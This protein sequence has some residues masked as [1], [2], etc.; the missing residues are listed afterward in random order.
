MDAFKGK[1]LEG[2]VA[3]SSHPRYAAPGEADPEWIS[4]AQRSRLIERSQNPPTVR[5]GLP[6][7]KDAPMKKEGDL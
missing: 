6:A 3:N 2:V 7:A 1:N 4:P 5:I